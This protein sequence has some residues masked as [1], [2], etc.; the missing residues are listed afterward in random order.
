M[1]RCNETTIYLTLYEINFEGYDYVL[2]WKNKLN[3]NSSFSLQF[4]CITRLIQEAL[5]WVDL[6]KQSW[7]VNEEWHSKFKRAF[8]AWYTQWASSIL[9][10]SPN[11]KQK[12]YQIV[13]IS[14][15]IVLLEN[16]IF[17][18]ESN[19]RKRWWARKD[20]SKSHLYGWNFIFHILF[21]D[22]KRWKFLEMIFCLILQCTWTAFTT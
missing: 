9:L 10:Y 11:L 3:S 15:S 4:S 22:W 21:S 20:Q 13:T 1:T 19:E 18:D 6:C 14:S 7:S 8:N 2:R 16:P 12:L 5:C 17:S